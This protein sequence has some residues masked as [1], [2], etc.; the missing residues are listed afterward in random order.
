MKTS[1]ILTKAKALIDKPEKWTIGAYARNGETAVPNDNKY[2]N[3]FC[4][5]G[6]VKRAG[7]ELEVEVYDALDALDNCAFYKHGFCSVIRFND[8]K[9]HPEVMALFDEAIAEAVKQES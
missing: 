8:S 1:E 9:T 7:Y 5:L 2:A 4:A 6:A 3:R